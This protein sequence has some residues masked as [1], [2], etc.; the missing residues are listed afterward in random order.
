MI[1]WVAK[2][3]SLGNPNRKTNYSKT[4]QKLSCEVT[5]GLGQVKDSQDPQITKQRLWSW[6]YYSKMLRSFPSRE[7]VM[8]RLGLF[9]SQFRHKNILKFLTQM[10]RLACCPK[11]LLQVFTVNLIRFSSFSLII[12]FINAS[13]NQTLWYQKCQHFW[14]K[15]NTKMCTLTSSI[16]MIENSQYSSR[17]AVALFSKTVITAIYSLE[18]LRM[19]FTKVF[20]KPIAFYVG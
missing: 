19:H 20:V 6:S 1:S 5:C 9:V 15:I 17:T 16:Q 14:V 2:L 10:T 18:M 12:W 13:Y 4:L 7:M 3:L 11:E 8:S